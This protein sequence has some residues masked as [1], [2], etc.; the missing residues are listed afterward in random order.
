L[1]VY[2]DFAFEEARNSLVEK[3]GK[4]LA[5]WRA[6]TVEG[7]ARIPVKLA[8]VE[9]VIGR[10]AKDWLAPQIAQVIAMMKSI[11]DGMASVDDVF[12]PLDAVGAAPVD[13]AQD[14][15]ESGEPGAP[16]KAAVPEFQRSTP[17]DDA[18]LETAAD[19]KLVPRTERDY[20]IWSEAW[21]ADLTDDRAGA[22]RWADEMRLRN[23]CNISPEIR[24]M[25]KE[26]LEEKLAELR[27]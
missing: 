5:G 13:T 22:R 11:A 10:H 23:N 15:P 18:G 9:R 16:E 1:Q 4:D 26:K 8:R 21:I 7:I 20:V 24:D 3:I 27:K 17:V 6:R 2:A 25:L 12:P 19:S 14:E